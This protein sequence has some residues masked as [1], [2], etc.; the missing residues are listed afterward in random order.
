MVMG[1]DGRIPVVV[2]TAE[3]ARPGDRVL[4]LAPGVARPGHAAGCPC[5]RPRD[6]V[7]TALGRLF[8]ERARDPTSAFSRV[9]LVAPDPHTEAAV[10][11]AIENDVLARARYRFAGRA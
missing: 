2:G 8:L 5:C 11:G 10:A 9:L 4:L 1:S 3:Q 6:A 7:A